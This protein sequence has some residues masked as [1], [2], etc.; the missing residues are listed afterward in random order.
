MEEERTEGRD[1]NPL[2]GAAERLPNPGA[3]RKQR[4]GGGAGD[5]GLGTQL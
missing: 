1:P 3:Q 2:R 4:G 5:G